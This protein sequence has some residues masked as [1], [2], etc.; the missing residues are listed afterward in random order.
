MV[1]KIICFLLSFTFSIV[2]YL[3]SDDF[4]QEPTSDPAQ[5]QLIAEENT[6]QAG[7]P[8]TVA[9]KMTIA[10][11]WHSYWKNPGEC[12]MPIQ[13]HWTLPEGFKTTELQWPTPKRFEQNGTIGYGY[14]NEAIFLTTIIPP[15][16][17]SIS[18]NF[19]I[20]AKVQ[21]LVCSDA[22][23]LPGESHLSLKIPQENTSSKHLFDEARVS[24]PTEGKQIKVSSS[25]KLIKIQLENVS[26]NKRAIFF[27]ESKHMIDESI[28]ALIQDTFVVLKE[29]SS[30]QTK[31]LKGVLLL[32]ND[33]STEAWDI[34]LP[35]EREGNLSL[36]ASADQPNLP[37]QSEEIAPKNSSAIKATSA[38]SQ[39]SFS[40]AFLFAFLGGLLLNLMPCVLPVVSL[41]V[42][43]FVK[44]ASECRRVTFQLGLAFFSGVIVSF[45]ALGGALL[46]LQSYGHSIGWGFQLQE[47]LFVA[48]LAA[49]LLLS[50]LSFFGVFEI[51]TSMTSMAGQAQQ[52]IRAK[53]S[54]LFSSFCS[55]ILATAVATPCT[56]PFLGAP[57]ALAVSLP[58]YLAL[59]IFTALGTGMALPY[60]LLAAYPS[61][62]R[63]IPKPGAWMGMFKELMGFFMLATVIWLLWV[64][65]G[66]T[67]NVSLFIL[68][69]A[70]FFLS[71]GAWI[72]GRWCTAVCSKFS[73][74]FGTLLTTCCV[75]ISLYALT[76]AA[77]IESSESSWEPYSPER[78]Q[79]LQM[80]GIPVFIDFT[81]KWCGICQFN[82]MVLSE[83]S[84]TKKLSELKVVKMKADW[85]SK[86]P[87]ITK[88]LNAFGRNGVPLYV[89]TSKN[90]DAEFS[91]LPQVLTPGIVIDY[92]EGLQ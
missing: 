46:L 89:L 6:L 44:M 5:F 92:L 87:T 91:I 41:K 39:M 17:L 18:E 1:T 16:N 59:L 12:G 52:N 2:P 83:S 53:K 74:Y 23:C 66:Q 21:W 37:L 70:L 38:D 40:L 48:L 55:G 15:P 60:L 3:C 86:D 79:E 10:D 71:F 9:I 65:Q 13:I 30:S 45:W 77:T 43:S 47:P 64:F 78:V 51:G 73:R 76:S 72:Y 58:P 69:F 25:N 22:A 82:H 32:E 88:A 36:I 54:A 4:H 75:A 27:P 28:P 34:D 26:S 57:I 35:I 14:E 19:T 31:N 84:V 49:L 63:F 67:S 68:L 29:N 61:L 33:T 11:E 42:L 8:L 24:I 20:E 90:N 7:M 81:A 62:L 85:T 50:A 80:Q 56:G